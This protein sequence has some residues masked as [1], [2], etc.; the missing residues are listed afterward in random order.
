MSNYKFKLLIKPEEIY[1]NLLPEQ[2]KLFDNIQITKAE[3]WNSGEVEIECL[4]LENDIKKTPYLQVM[5]FSN[6]KYI[7]VKES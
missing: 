3:L 5:S 6:G 7:T 4:A 1:S 2:K